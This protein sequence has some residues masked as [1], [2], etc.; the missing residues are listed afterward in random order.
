MQGTHWVLWVQKIKKFRAAPRF[1]DQLAL[2]PPP[3]PRPEPRGRIAPEPSTREPRTQ[4][5]HGS[6]GPFPFSQRVHKPRETQRVALNPRTQRVHGFHE[7]I[8]AGRPTGARKPGK[9]ATQ[10]V[11][12]G[13]CD[14]LHFRAGEAQETYFF[15]WVFFFENPRIH[16]SR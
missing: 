14:K 11:K 13:H 15:H 4:R 5:V 9:R 2:G 6:P 1:R 3:P 16:P 10:R 12:R 7:S 8:G